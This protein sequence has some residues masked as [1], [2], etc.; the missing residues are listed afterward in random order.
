MANEIV[1]PAELPP[2]ANP[3]A[4]EVVPSDNGSVVGGVTW[5]AGVNAGRPLANQV[6]AETGANA[7][8]S[9]TPLTTKQAIDAQVPGK[10]S[11]AI[12][13]LNLGT[14]AQEDVE[15]FATAAQ[16]VK[17][18]TAVQPS[19]EIIAGDGL[20]GAGDL[21]A[22]RTINVGAGTGIEVSADAVG[23]DAATLASLVKADEAVSYAPQVLT[24]TQALQAQAN[25]SLLRLATVADLVDDTTLDYAAGS[26][27][28]EVGAGDIVEAEGFRYQVAD[29]GASDQHIT[30]A[31][32]VKLYVV[33]DTD[34]VFA[35]AFGV[36]ADNVTDDGP[37]LNLCIQA[38]PQGT[39]I[40]LPVRGTMRIA[41][42]VNVNRCVTIYGGFATHR[43]AGLGAIQGACARVEGAITAFSVTATGAA[44]VG[45]K[46]YGDRTPD[47]IG[48]YYNQPYVL[49]EHV[50]I[51][52]VDIGIHVNGG[53]HTRMAHLRLRNIRFIVIWLQ[54]G[55]GPRLHDVFYDTDGEWY[56]GGTYP[57][58]T[59]GVVVQCEGVQMSDC[60]FI[61]AGQGL[62]IN[63]SADRHVEWCLFVNSFFDSCLGRPGIWIRNNTA[64]RC[65]GL[66]FTGMWSATCGQGIYISGTGTIDGVY[67]TGGVIHNSANENVR[68]DAANAFNIKF[69]GAV[70]AGPN[71]GGGSANN[72]FTATAGKVAFNDCEFG[73]QISWASQPWTHIFTGAGQT[74]QVD[75]SGSYFDKNGV[76]SAVFNKGGSGPIII[77]GCR[78]IVRK[79]R[80]TAQ[81]ASGNTSVTI[82]HG[83]D[84]PVSDASVTIWPLNGWGSA[85]QWWTDDV[86]TPSAGQF[87][88]VA[89]VN[90]AANMQF[91]WVAEVDQL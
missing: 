69:V 9:M 71:A 89:N 20:T 37:A 63:V 58:P 16:G 59:S 32:G 88:I 62:D 76:L 7:S 86:G 14:A 52:L 72:V 26:G 49:I 61:H 45:F 2:R 56:P 80:G 19:R 24:A 1:R 68:I 84:V 82:N 85:S 15:A 3:V 50:V 51:E 66:F 13:D 91:G 39:T 25:M 35:R 5:A 18:D 42:T 27:K 11:Q 83:L 41:T 70:L 77:N 65:R 17:A 47:Q 36:A 55:V 6:E 38:C 34:I 31:G 81:I 8:K 29:S 21:S 4:S 87:K 57:Q 10:I 12:A 79:S 44:L 46:I 90:P 73:R 74:G 78:G 43:T 60:D 53:N 40:I 54:D 67:W 28:V 75:C 22:D 64:N 23:L 33:V 48:I 30:T